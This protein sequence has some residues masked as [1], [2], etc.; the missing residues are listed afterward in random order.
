M[1]FIICAD[2]IL[3]L[4]YNTVYSWTFV[5]DRTDRSVARSLEYMLTLFELCGLTLIQ[6]KLQTDFPDELYPVHMFALVPN[7]IGRAHV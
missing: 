3:L 7:E 5:V 2:C 4:L 6:R 1:L